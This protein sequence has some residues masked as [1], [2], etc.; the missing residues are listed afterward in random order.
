MLAQYTLPIFSLCRS[1]NHFS[2]SFFVTALPFT[3][4]F[5]EGC[6]VEPFNSVVTLVIP[7]TSVDVVETIMSSS[8]ERSLSESSVVSTDL[9]RFWDSL[10]RSV[11]DETVR[12]KEFFW[13]WIKHRTENIAYRSEK[14]M[15]WALFW[16]HIQ[17]TNGIQRNKQDSGQWV[18]ILAIFSRG[19]ALDPWLTKPTNLQVTQDLEKNKEEHCV[20][21]I[22]P[23]M[24]AYNPEWH[25][26]WYAICSHTKKW[27][28]GYAIWWWN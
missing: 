12:F 24:I 25:A 7:C 26:N 6:L 5:F 20:S 13:I 27:V 8:L 4:R 1:H 17:G 19:A 10:I 18:E 11:V 3:R 2:K 21:L 15:N 16:G 23:W 22:R 14:R 9:L 28:C